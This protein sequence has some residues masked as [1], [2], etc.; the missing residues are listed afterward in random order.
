MPPQKY[1]FS[2]TSCTDDI[3]QG[4][5]LRKGRVQYTFLQHPH[6]HHPTTFTLLHCTIKIVP[7]ARTF[8]SSECSV[9]LLS[10]L[11]TWLHCSVVVK[12]ISIRL[13]VL[14]T[15]R[16][17]CKSKSHD[18]ILYI[19]HVNSLWLLGVCFALHS[20]SSRELRPLTTFAHRKD[21]IMQIAKLQDQ[22]YTGLTL[23][24]QL[25]LPL[26]CLTLQW[27]SDI[28]YSDSA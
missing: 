28:T 19:M 25:T 6:R 9:S 16:T 21:L 11:C 2:W 3:F 5:P 26:S 24:L 4:D 23:Q 1:K 22:V 20:V 7:S 18:H 10:G 17:Y 15:C 8:N 14:H 13:D 12:P 27:R